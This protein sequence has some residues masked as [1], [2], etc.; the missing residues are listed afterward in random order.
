MK[1][2]VKRSYIY[3]LT[4]VIFFFSFAIAQ[5]NPP[6][7]SELKKYTMQLVY[8][9]DRDQTEYI[10]VLGQSGFRTLEAF[11]KQVAKLPHGSILE[12][13]PGCV[14]FGNEPLLSSERDMDEFKGFCK[15]KGI[16]FILIPSG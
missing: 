4:I 5:Q 9:F 11:K 6:R 14:R 7:E 2:L 3:I 12:W 8:I 16:K 15:S 10:L 13:A 1:A